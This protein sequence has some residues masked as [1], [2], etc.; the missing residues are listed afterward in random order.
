MPP[1]LNATMPAAPQTMED[2]SPISPPEI[3][4]SDEMPVPPTMPPAATAAPE[5]P[6]VPAM[7]EVSSCL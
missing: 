6:A 5:A 7:P 4:F 3:A 2:V 1:T